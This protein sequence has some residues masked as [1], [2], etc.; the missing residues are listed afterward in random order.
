[1]SNPRNNGIVTGHLAAD[2]KVFTNSDGSHKILFTVYAARDYTNKAGV[3]ES[4]AIG[5]EA[6]IPAGATNLGP[7]AHMH[8]GDLV[9]VGYSLRMDSYATEGGEKR[10]DL[11]VVARDIALLGAKS[12]K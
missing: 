2:P 4:D 10:F 5:F 12:A 9:S 1:M 8:T 6:F 7:Y 3:R 11:K